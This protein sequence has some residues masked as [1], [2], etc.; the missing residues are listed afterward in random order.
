MD[1]GIGI[2]DKYTGFNI[3]VW[4]DMTIEPATGNI[5]A[6]SID[7]RILRCSPPAKA[8]RRDADS[9]AASWLRHVLRGDSES[10]RGTLYDESGC[11]FV[12]KII[13]RASFYVYNNIS[14]SSGKSAACRIASV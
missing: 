8:C 14:I 5:C 4:I 10:V 3:S 6:L 7:H 9:D 1:V 11:Q 12:R 2:M 13:A